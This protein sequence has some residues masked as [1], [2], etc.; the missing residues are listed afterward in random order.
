MKYIPDSRI[1]HEI[2]KFNFDSHINL[3][4]SRKIF[5]IIQNNDM[6]LSTKSQG[7]INHVKDNTSDDI[8]MCTAAKKNVAQI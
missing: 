6:H 5:E 1:L 2:K 8:R 3:P 4:R 7:Y